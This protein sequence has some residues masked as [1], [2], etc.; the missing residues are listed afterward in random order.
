VF[1]RVRALHR[2]PGGARTHAQCHLVFPDADIL[3][4]SAAARSFHCP[5]GSAQS[6][7]SG[8][9]NAKGSG[10]YEFGWRINAVSHAS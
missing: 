6:L 7:V 9:K 2:V 4:T 1:S 3:R 5:P 10:I 8:L